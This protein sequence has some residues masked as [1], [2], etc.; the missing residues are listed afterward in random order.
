MGAA[1]TAKAATKA[2]LRRARGIVSFKVV[3]AA[4]PSSRSEDPP[5]PVPEPLENGL[6]LGA[7]EF[8]R[9]YEAMPDVKKAELIDGIV[10]MGSP[11]RFDKHSE[12]DNMIQGWLWVYKIE[13]PGVSA[14]V[15]PTLRLGSDDVLQPDALLC[16]NQEC[17]GRSRLDLKGYV[18]GSP[19]LVVEIAASSAS[20]DARQKHD[21]Y[22]R[23]GVREYLL[24]RTVERALDWWVLEEE[25]YQLLIP[26]AQGIVRS[27]VFPGLWLDATALL[28]GDSR[29]VLA[30]LQ[31]GLRSQEHSAFVSSLENARQQNPDG[32][33][34]KN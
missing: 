3:I 32:S 8:L 29:R 9:R 21:S 31:E 20:I 16:V 25:R 12:P 1:Q 5:Q 11:V 2:E 34:R 23:A 28:A 14:G 19:E 24:W 33:Q 17:G 26:D 22:R 4:V 6:H 30:K 10:Y 7:T 15:G 13:T 18:E 27:R